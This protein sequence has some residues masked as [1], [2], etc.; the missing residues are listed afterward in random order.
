[1]RVP[2]PVV[3]GSVILA[4]AVCWWLRTRHMDFLSP[5]GTFKP[6][7]EFMTDPVKPEVAS[8][9]PPE[10]EVSTAETPSATPETDLD[11]GD[12]ESAPGLAEY[13]EHASKGAGHMVSLA[14]ELESNGQWE[15]SLLAWERVLDSCRP[16]PQERKTAEDAIARIRPTLTHWNID[17][18]GDIPITLEITTRR[19][20]SENQKVAVREAAEF[21][22]G[23]SDNILLIEARVSSSSRN[24]TEDLPV[25]IHFS[26]PSRSSSKSRSLA[27]GNDA[28]EHHRLLI[29]TSA[30]QLVRQELADLEGIVSPEN[31]SN[32]GDPKLDFQ[33]QITR[34]HWFRFAESLNQIADSGNS[35]R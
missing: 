32:P 19:T 23:N 16:S 12:L 25:S 28:V 10:A 17:P 33:R 8:G 29:L 9:P 35:R 21:L 26:R 11:L 22:R 31:S 20:A 6:L 4:A 34:L 27:P 2:V 1:M 13:S 3:I 15:R 7:P 24:T 14:T 30:Y 18:A 5:A